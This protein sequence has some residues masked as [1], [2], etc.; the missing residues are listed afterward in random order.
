MTCRVVVLASG[1]GTLLQ[2][3]L[4]APDVDVVGLVT[5]VAD[6]TA[7][8]RARSASVPVTA[9][10]LADHPS[11]AAWDVAIADAIGAFAP[12]WVVSAGFMRILGSAVLTVFPGRII[13]SHPSLLPHFPGAHAVADALAA[14]VA[15]TG[16]TVHVVDAGVDTGP[17]LA[18]VRVEV[19][20]GD[21]VASLHERIKQQERR[22]LVDVV[23]GLCAGTLAVP[24]Q[25][26]GT[27]T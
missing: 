10:P 18:Q 12:T 13:N 7:V 25:E 21:D 17:V 15:T 24:V 4:D 2:A 19:A 6:C 27:P 11:R 3:L 22:L 14:R 8:E 9:V 5:D 23:R 20:P 26:G 1:S 16:C